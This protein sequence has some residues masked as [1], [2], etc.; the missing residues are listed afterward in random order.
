MALPHVLPPPPEMPLTRSHFQHIPLGLAGKI[1][2]PAPFEPLH[3]S[4][5]RA[6]GDRH[7]RQGGCVMGHSSGLGDLL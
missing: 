6:G 1:F 2:G 3:I 4:A 7:W 5:T